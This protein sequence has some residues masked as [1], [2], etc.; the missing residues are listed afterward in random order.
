MVTA[1]QP[2]ATDILMKGN[3][4]VVSEMKNKLQ[5]AMTNIM[6]DTMHADQMKKQ[7]EPVNKD[8]YQ[9]DGTVYVLR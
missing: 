6:P 2:G 7:S 5:P 8:R 9:I 4:K 3:D 1:L